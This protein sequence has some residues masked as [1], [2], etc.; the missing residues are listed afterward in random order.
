MLMQPWGITLADMN[1]S[2]LLFMLLLRQLG[3]CPSCCVA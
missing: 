3:T 2:Q 1:S